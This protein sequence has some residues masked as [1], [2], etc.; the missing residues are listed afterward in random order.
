MLLSPLLLLFSFLTLSQ[1]KPIL[2]PPPSTNTLL[3]HF[4][5]SSPIHYPTFLDYLPRKC[6]DWAN[7]TANVIEQ[8]CYI[9]LDIFYEKEVKQRQQ[10]LYE[11]V[12]KGNRPVGRD[13]PIWLPQAV[14]Y[15][16][17]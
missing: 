12:T 5:L 2:S 14:R 6:T 11:F 3:P 15:G 13:K 8:D 16:R 9:A 17:L 1:T 7:W 4:N 10:T